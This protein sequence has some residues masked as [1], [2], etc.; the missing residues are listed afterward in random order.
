MTMMTSRSFCGGVRTDQAW[1][2][3]RARVNYADQGTLLAF[4]QQLG[5]RELAVGLAGED[6][7]VSFSSGN[8]RWEVEHRGSGV[9]AGENDT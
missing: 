1:A 9:G 3:G 4:P 2:I 5:P 8:L 6:C 7:A